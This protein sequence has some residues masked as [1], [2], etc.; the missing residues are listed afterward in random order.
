ME[1][2]NPE[3]DTILD[4]LS[5]NRWIPFTQDTSKELFNAKDKLFALGLLEPHNEY[6]WKLT[7]EGHRAIEL[8]GFDKWMKTQQPKSFFNRLLSLIVKFIWEILVGVLIILIGLA[9]EYK[10]FVK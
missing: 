8:G 9:I 3:I 2:N 10:W 1:K 6:S 4:Y 7:K 5:D